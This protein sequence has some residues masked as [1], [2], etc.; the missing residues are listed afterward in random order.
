MAVRDELSDESSTSSKCKRIQPAVE[1]LEDFG[2]VIK[3][4][5]AKNEKSYEI[6]C[7]LKTKSDSLRKHWL[8]ILSDELYGY[9]DQNKTAQVLMHS[10]RGVF[11]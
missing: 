1:A 8:V 9:K 5:E 11:I 7:L 3:T 4:S 2:K 6:E 10:L